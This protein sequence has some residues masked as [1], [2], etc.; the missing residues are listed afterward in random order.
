VEKR[1]A[2]AGIAA[3]VDLAAPMEFLEKEASRTEGLRL[4]L[5]GPMI[6]ARGGYPVA[7]WGRDGY[8]L[9][10][11]TEVE[12][13]RAVERL[14]G[15][16]ARIIKL[17][18]TAAPV[19]SEAVLKA[20]A[21]RA[22]ELGLKV[23]CHALSD[24]EALLAA[25]IGADLLAHTPVEPLS[26][27]TLEAWKG[28]AVISTLLAFGGSEAA[29]DNLRKLRAAGA[30]VLYGTDLGNTRTPAIDGKEI[31]LLQKAGLDGAAILQAGTGAPAKYWGF[32]GL[33]SLD[34]GS[35]G[36]VI[37]LEEDPLLDPVTLSRPL[38]VF[39]DGEQL[40]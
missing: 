33:G 40:R 27:E 38:Q 1:L 18:I 34:R 22:H 11:V 24:R 13:S 21:T 4:V 16:G 8:G 32:E 17:P 2:Q 6:T 28:K 7:S 3:A 14:H 12:A 20:A 9:E 31:E 15:A 10:V 35:A 26:D 25:A 37:V 30:L 29:V 39:L 36:C 19:L 5:S 23:T